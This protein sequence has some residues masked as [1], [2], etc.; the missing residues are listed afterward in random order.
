LAFVCTVVAAVVLITHFR[1]Q[2]APKPT[3]RKLQVVN[4][5]DDDD[6]D[7][8]NDVLGTC[9]NCAFFDLEEGQAVIKQ[10]PIFLQAASH[11][12]PNVMMRKLDKAGNELPN[13]HALRA[14]HDN[15]ALFGACDANEQLRHSTDTCE[16]Y[17][18]RKRHV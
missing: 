1:K 6:E 10:N 3:K 13:E 14:K 17:K 8:D 2:A 4:E 18:M 12:S 15:W 9:A 7:T 16:K 5:D 11:V